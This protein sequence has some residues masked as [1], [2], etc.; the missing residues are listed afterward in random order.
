MVKRIYKENRKAVKQ[1]IIRLDANQYKALSRH[2]D[3]L[4]KEQGERATWA[5]TVMSG[6]MAVLLLKSLENAKARKAG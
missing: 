2:R 6:T 5:E 4:S 1:V 3:E